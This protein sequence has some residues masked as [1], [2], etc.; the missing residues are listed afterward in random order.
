MKR[1]ADG[2][3]LYTRSKRPV[4]VAPY[5]RPKRFV[6]WVS[7]TDVKN[8]MLGD[9]LVDWLKITKT[10]PHT[11]S[12]I[13]LN[14]HKK[15]DP[16]LAERGKDFERQ[17]V[18]YIHT[19]KHPVLSLSDRITDQSCRETVRAIRD[20]IPFIHSAPFRH[21]KSQTHGVIDFLV[22]SDYLHLLTN[23][24]PDPTYPPYYVV[25]DAKFSTLPLRADG[26]YLLNSGNY[27]AYKAQLWI[28][29]RAIGAIQG[30]TSR[31]AYILG[32]RN[33]YTEKGQS[34]TNLDCFNRLGVVDYQGI[35]SSFRE[36][37]EK[38]IAWV[39]EVR[40]HGREWSA[41][42]PTRPELY[43]NMCIHS[44][45]WHHDK[46]TIAERLGEITQLWYC[47]V[48]E[49]Q[50]ALAQGIYSWRDERCSGKTLGL[51]EG[52]SSIV[53]KI[54]DINRQT[55]DKIRPK[56]IS[57]TLLNWNIP[58]N[59]AVVDFETFTDVFA[60]FDKLPSQPRTDTLFL[61][62]VYYK[63]VYHR[64]IARSATREEEI[65]IMKEFLLFL[66]LHN[67]PKLWHWHAD[68]SIWERARRRHPGLETELNNPATVLRWA[69]LC[70]VFRAE[71]IVIKDCFKF[72]LKEIASAMFKHG[73]ITTNLETDLCRNGMDAAQVAWTVYKDNPN[74][75]TDPRMNDI[76]NYNAFDVKVVW[77]ILTYL[78]THHV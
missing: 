1:K 5:S 55:V 70:R 23:T 3:W 31:Y 61:I 53:D 44:G 25:I 59:E 72:G 51:S 57:H 68:Q 22:R 77:E 47:G 71:P 14:T 29:T 15:P 52:R 32:R 16:F 33:R 62:G 21:Y 42:P 19:H 18:N 60:S 13:S 69:D 30:Y 34:Y 26:K 20:G 7:A 39:K 11:S 8:Y 46:Q 75:L 17:L 28:Y 41:S 76:I 67:F 78:R 10:K 66:E 58:E 24:A 56:Q 54:I 50:K 4:L 43:P 65:R 2:P 64:F 27:P 6:S 45:P 49:R 40:R 9:S 38:A 74:P 36:T 37:T 73:L 63:D 35:D 48:R 12:I